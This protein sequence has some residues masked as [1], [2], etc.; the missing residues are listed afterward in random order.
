MSALPPLPPLQPADPARF[1]TGVLADQH[2]QKGVQFEQQGE[3]ERALAAYRKA[4]SLD[5]HRVLFLLA[6]GRVCQGHGLEPEAE[7]CYRLALRL[8]PDDPVV[9][10]NQAQ[11]F[12]AR[13]HLD[14]ARA[15]LAKI[16][17][18]DVDRLGDRAAPIFCRLGDIALRR[19][20]YAAAA[21]YFR[22]ALA[23]A[24][25]HRYAAVTLE[26]LERFAE[27][28]APFAPD[29]FVSPKVAL[30]GY[31]GA[32]LLG[33][34][35]D[36]GVEVPP[37]PGLGFDS[38]TELALARFVA[39]ARGGGWAY[40][41]VAPLDQESQPLAVALAAALEARAV[42][43]VAHVPW[44]GRALGVSAT[45][46]N[47]Q[48]LHAAT[49]ALLERS[50]SATLYALGLREAI[51]EYHPAPHVVNVPIRLEFPWNRG[52]AAAPEH[53][54]AYGAEL[55][56]ALAQ[57]QLELAGELDDFTRRQWRWYTQHP[58]LRLDLHPTHQPV[59]APSLLA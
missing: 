32:A 1:F 52:E 3:W 35:G 46:T 11:L 42:P 17:D 51:W 5:A 44:G 40:E 45:G 27:F 26:A 33:M 50:P 15:N 34:A 38:L 49:G 23:Y 19:E 30:Y 48:A 59:V 29:G 7:E 31:A 37:Y 20:D 54:E 10:Y 57:V 18:G 56:Q 41:V 6:R 53:A 36:D 47:P 21:L 12:A 2:Y 43:A 22:R 16:V 58:H 14:A 9:L 28:E 24:P 8:R 55:A 4:S 25:D 39:L 13:G